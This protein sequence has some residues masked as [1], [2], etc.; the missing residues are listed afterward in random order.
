VGDWRSEQIEH[1]RGLTLW[2][3]KYT[4]WSAEWDHDHCAACSAKFMENDADALHEGYATGP[5]Y[6][7]GARYE[8]LC[9]QCFSDL[10]DE[11]NL[12]LGSATISKIESP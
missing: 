10:K 12:S 8:W 3:S 6:K 1:L 5:D 9:E 11:L 4:R 7:L 2:K